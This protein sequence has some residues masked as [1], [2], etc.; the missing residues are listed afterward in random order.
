MSDTNLDD[1]FDIMEKNPDPVIDYV[2]NTKVK[3][4]K[5]GQV[6]INEV[7]KQLGGLVD[8]GKKILT[9]AEFLVD[10]SGDAESIAGSASLINAIKDTIKEFNRLYLDDMKFQRQF[11]LEKMKQAHK[12]ELLEM[13]LQKKDKKTID[14]EDLVEFNQEKIVAL[15]SQQ[16]V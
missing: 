12:K 13:K 7:Y 4:H 5:N 8:T 6:D 16:Y 10:S 11:E 3:L 2:E 9:A 1:I 14:C 15:L